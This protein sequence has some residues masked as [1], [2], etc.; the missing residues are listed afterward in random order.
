MK[1]SEATQFLRSKGYLVE[2]HVLNQAAKSKDDEFYTYMKD[3]VKELKHYNF[4]GKI[5]YCCCDN[6]E[7]SNFYKYFRDNFDSLGLKGLISSHYEENGKPESHRPSV[8]WS[9]IGFPVFC[10]VCSRGQLEVCRLFGCLFF[11]AHLFL[12]KLQQSFGLWFTFFSQYLKCLF[13][14]SH[15]LTSLKPVIFAKYC[16][17]MNRGKC[18]YPARIY[19]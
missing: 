11:F 19:L 3:I 6:P 17:F 16:C 10:S 13:T 5:V 12:L 8:K 4:S 18:W 15:T 2:K 9:G 1:L 14:S 7:W